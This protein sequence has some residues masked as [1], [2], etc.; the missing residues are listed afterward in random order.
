MI[1]FF[2]YFGISLEVST[3]IKFNKSGM[4]YLV[5]KKQTESNA[6]TFRNILREFED[7]AVY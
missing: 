3:Y 6:E 4:F 1:S 2:G 5:M 7:T